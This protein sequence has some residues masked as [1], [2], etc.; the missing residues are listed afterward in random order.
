MCC[1][2]DNDNLSS[3]NADPNTEFPQYAQKHL[4]QAEHTRAL[5]Q[6]LLV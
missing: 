3:V 1:N 2:Q 5:P 4:Q 6:H